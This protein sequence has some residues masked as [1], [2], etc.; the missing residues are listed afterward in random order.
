MKITLNLLKVDY[1]SFDSTP[2]NISCHQSS[3]NLIDNF[4]VSL[5]LQYIHN[6]LFFVYETYR[7]FN[8]KRILNYWG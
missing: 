3:S 7:L 8:W 5:G 6:T 4:G 1:S 2:Y